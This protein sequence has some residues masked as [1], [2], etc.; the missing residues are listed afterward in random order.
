MADKKGFIAEFKEFIMRGNVLDMAVGVIVGGAFSTIVKSLVDDVL[1][2]V[3]TLVT[4]GLN[5][6]DWFISLNGEKFATLAEAQEAG[7]ATLNYGM[8]INNIIYF[9][10]VA[11][12]I[13]LLIK[14]INK[15]HK[16]PEEA[17][18]PVTTKICPFC[19]SEIPLEATRCGHCTSQLEA[20]K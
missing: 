3:I 6:Q 13:F 8:F 20:D 5:F 15:L 11:L 18:A 16:K 12:M 1:M 19:K 10:L 14:G 17:P 4:G 7:A 2:P 9:L